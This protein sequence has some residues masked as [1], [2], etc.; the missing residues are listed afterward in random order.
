[1][2][3]EG[4]ESRQAVGQGRGGEALRAPRVS[5]KRVGAWRCPMPSACFPRLAARSCTRCGSSHALRIAPGGPPPRTPTVRAQK[6]RKVT[7]LDPKKF[8]RLRL[9]R[10]A[11]ADLARATPPAAVL[12]QALGGCNS[13]AVSKGSAGMQ[14]QLSEAEVL[15]GAVSG[16]LAFHQARAV[17]VLRRAL[18]ELLAADATTDAARS[19]S[20]MTADEPAPPAAST[21]DDTRVSTAPRKSTPLSSAKR[22]GTDWPEMREQLCAACTERGVSRRRLA[23]ELGMAHGTIRSTLAPS[24]K[25]PSDAMRARLRGWLDNGSTSAPAVAATGATFPAG[26][27]SAGDMVAQA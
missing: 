23:G 26:R 14:Q 8:L 10:P 7:T 3:S 5:S 20:T 17:H 12:D 1:M 4:L 22:N 19:T 27:N 18:S 24:G 9:L 6:G 2:V 11:H 13:R 16:L 21:I 25:P 15:L